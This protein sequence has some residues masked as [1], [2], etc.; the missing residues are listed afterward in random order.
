MTLPQPY[1]NFITEDDMD[2]LGELIHDPDIFE[3][4]MQD[5]QYDDDEDKTNITTL[6]LSPT[7][8]QKRS[9]LC[10]FTT[11]VQPILSPNISDMKV[12]ISFKSLQE[13]P[14]W[15]KKWQSSQS[16]QENS[17]H[18]SAIILKKALYDFFIGTVRVGGE[19]EISPASFIKTYKENNVQLLP[20]IIVNTEANPLN[21]PDF[22]NI[23]DASCPLTLQ[24][25]YIVCGKN[26]VSHA[27]LMIFDNIRREAYYFDSNGPDSITTPRIC[28]E[29]LAK[30]A[31]KI[32]YKTSHFNMPARP[33]LVVREP[34][35]AAWS[36]LASFVATRKILFG[37]PPLLDNRDF[38][39]LNHEL[40]NDMMNYGLDEVITYFMKYCIRHIYGVEAIFINQYKKFQALKETIILQG[41]TLPDRT[42]LEKIFI[43]NEGSIG[44]CMDYFLQHYTTSI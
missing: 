42:I 5:L 29:Y 9:T 38:Y 39:L 11:I 18:L 4:L 7:T 2:N 35:C 27:T 10:A 25:L 1:I 16:F 33:Q 24:F 37:E 40:D 8:E 15:W 14:L 22:S 20:P 12:D 34:G 26:P 19:R 31:Q 6:P 17:S 21:I 44:K 41:L 30:S 32:S 3:N 43:E 28:R 23:I 13:E 36:L